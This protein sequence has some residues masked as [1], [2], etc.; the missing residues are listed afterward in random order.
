M[1][2]SLT[3]REKAAMIEAQQGLCGCGCGQ[4]VTMAN[5]DGE[6]GLAVGLGNRGKPD[7]VWRRDCHK[8]KSAA[9]LKMIRKA[10]RQRK[11]HLGEKKR[12]GRKLQGRGFTGW[13]KFDGTIVRAD[14]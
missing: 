1:R 8:P 11:A 6:H 3:R 7:A 2:R 5:G 13:R 9:D 14:A 10:D 4:E 12:R